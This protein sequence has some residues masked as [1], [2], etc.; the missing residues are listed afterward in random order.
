MSHILDEDQAYRAMLRFLEDAYIRNPKWELGGILG[1]MSLLEDGLPADRAM[2]KDW[3]A[4]V[5]HTLSDK[6]LE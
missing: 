3:L 1:S 4:A 6:A 2:Q 5:T